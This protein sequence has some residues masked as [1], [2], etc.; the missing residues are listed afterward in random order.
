M[1]EET[2]MDKP[3]DAGLK[4]EFDQYNTTNVEEYNKPDFNKDDGTV[5]KAKLDNFNR[6]GVPK[7]E[8]GE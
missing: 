4:E 3:N 7:K 1:K 2:V 6:I 8:K 5:L